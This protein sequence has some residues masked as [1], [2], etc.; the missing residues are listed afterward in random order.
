MNLTF[1]YFDFPFWRSEVGKLA[2]HLGNVDFE[3]KIIS[4]DEFQR[5]KKTGQLD[6]GTIIPFHQLPCL[7]V[8][9]IPIAQTAG[10]ARFCGK[11]SGL[12]PKD[13]D[14]LAGQ[15]DQ[16]LD[17]IT[18][19]TVIV[20]WTGKDD[21]DEARIIKRGDLAQGELGRKLRMLE[22]NI[23]NNS[24]WALGDKMGLPDIAIW[25]FMGWL[26][27]GSVEGLPTDILKDY[28]NIRRLCHSVDQN[29]R[30]QDWIDSTYPENYNRGNYLID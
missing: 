18:D 8:D 4:G 15:I 27:C 7:L 24:T 1:I 26:S 30:I 12:Y 28:P 16:I 2:L 10:I 23:L 9:D 14:V 11:L 3:N 6:D 5:V 21:N 29:P 19:M 20:A 13:N 25:R 17:F 22:K